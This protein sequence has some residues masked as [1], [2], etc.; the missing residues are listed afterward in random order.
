VC[1][2][3]V[4]TGFVVL[5]SYKYIRYIGN[6]H[7]PS[8]SPFTLPYPTST[9]PSIEPFLL[10]VLQFLSVYFLF[11][12]VSSQYSTHAY[13]NEINPSITLFLFPLDPYISTAFCAIH[14]EIFALDQP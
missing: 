9:H 13:F 1:L 12:G 8:P 11:K 4:S 5:F 3:T 6:I 2:K 10:P 7:L 14:Y